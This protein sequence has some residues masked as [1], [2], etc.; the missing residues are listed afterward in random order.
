MNTPPIVHLRLVIPEFAVGSGNLGEHIPTTATFR[1]GW[2]ALR[3]CV[4]SRSRLSG[5]LYGGQHHRKPEWP[6]VFGLSH[7]WVNVQGES[8]GVLME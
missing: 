8:S 1:C 5:Q 3:P 6:S 2:C 4:E 7:L